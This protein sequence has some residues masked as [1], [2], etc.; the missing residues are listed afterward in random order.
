[1]IDS[2][3]PVDNSAG[4]TLYLNLKAEYF[5]AIKF[6]TK[7]EEYRLA[8]PYW[9]KRLQGKAYTRIV[10]RKGYPA[11]GDINRNLE[12]PWAG[13][14]RQTICHP[15]FGKHPVSVFAIKVN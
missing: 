12:R 2:T 15:H 3:M 13:M 1:M 14:T 11:R 10:L 4:E 8:T 9:E 7:L 6:G 5:D